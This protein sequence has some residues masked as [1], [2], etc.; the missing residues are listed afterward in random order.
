MHAYR[1]SKHKIV[2]RGLVIFAFPAVL[3]TH[4]NVS[5]RLN[6]LY[7]AHIP[8]KNALAL[9]YGSVLV[10]TLKRKLIIIADMHYL[11]P[12]SEYILAGNALVLK[13]R[14]RVK[15]VLQ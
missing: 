12:F 7:R 6:P 10:K 2:K 9:N 1:I 13:G 5:A 11:I 8:V 3:K 4:S 14:G 15:R